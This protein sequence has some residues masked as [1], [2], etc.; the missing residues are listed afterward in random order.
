[1]SNINWKYV[2]EFSCIVETLK[3]LDTLGI[4]LACDFHPRVPGDALVVLE[5]EKEKIMDLPFKSYSDDRERAENY[6]GGLRVWRM[7]D[8]SSFRGLNR[9]EDIRREYN[10]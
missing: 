1:M 8:V 7:T 3:S 9:L 10:V 2:V 4:V 5:V 6:M